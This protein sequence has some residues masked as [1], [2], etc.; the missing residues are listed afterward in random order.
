MGWG[1]CMTG[2]AFRIL[3]YSYLNE[4]RIPAG[5]GG[6][7]LVLVNTQLLR[8]SVRP[9]VRSYTVSELFA[10]CL[11]VTCEYHYLGL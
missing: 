11:F 1:M 7:L 2:D 10:Y 6:G 8:P 3:Y 4:V 9:Y 5:V